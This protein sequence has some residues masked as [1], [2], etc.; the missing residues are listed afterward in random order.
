MQY[1][2]A[3]PRLIVHAS[4]SNTVAK[5]CSHL[6]HT[7][8]NVSETMIPILMSTSVG[9]LFGQERDANNAQSSGT[10]QKMWK[11]VF[12]AV[13]HHHKGT[14][15]CQKTKRRTIVDKTFHTVPEYMIYGEVD[16]KKPCT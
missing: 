2:K 4:L 7:L 11:L 3:M 12:L 8:T 9:S 14:N 13:F 15:I 5:T 1:K 16:T 10:A 6:A